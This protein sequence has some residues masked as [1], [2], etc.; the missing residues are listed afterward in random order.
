MRI[1]ENVDLQYID[2]TTKLYAMT[3]AVPIPEVGEKRWIRCRG[4]ELRGVT[5]L[6]DEREV[7]SARLPGRI[8]LCI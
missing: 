4:F 3:L 5:R 6:R 8:F 1:K 7:L 2:K